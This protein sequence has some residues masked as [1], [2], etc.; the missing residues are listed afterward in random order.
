MHRRLEIITLGLAGLAILATGVTGLV[1]P[2]ALFTPLELQIAGV[3]AM[4]EIRAAYGG[5]HLGIGL[6][7]LAGAWR[8]EFR[9][10]AL[11]VGLAFMGGLTVGR[12]VSLVVDGTPSAF[13]FQLWIPETGAAVAIATLLF[14]RGHAR[15]S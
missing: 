8:P 15:N 7:L 3:S 1:D 5:M 11:W 4:N 10:T 12:G 14:T 6:L 13:V 9:R 2:Q